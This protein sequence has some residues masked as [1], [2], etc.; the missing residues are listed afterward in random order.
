VATRFVAQPPLTRDDDDRAFAPPPA[1]DEESNYANAVDVM[2]LRPLSH[3]FLFE[4]HGEAANVNSLDEVPDSSWFENRAVR[5]EELARGPCSEEEPVLPLLIKKSKSGGTT[6]GFL[7]EDAL[8]R[9]YMVKLDSMPD[10][11][12]ELSTAADAIVSRLYWAVGF[13]APC[14]EVV[15]ARSEQ[16]RVDPRATETLATGDK[17]L[18]SAE[19]V[20]QLLSRATRRSD[21]AVRIG[22]S[23]FIAGEPI[24]TWRTEGTRTDD[25]NDVIPHE[26]RRELR[27]EYLLAAW[28]AHWDSRGPNSFDTFVRRPGAAAGHGVHYFLDFSE[29]L[30]GYGPALPGLQ[31]R[32]GY[33][34]VTDAP[35]IFTDFV[36]LGLTRKPWDDLAVDPRFPNLGYFDAEH[37][38]PARFAPQTPQVRWARAERADLAWMARRLARLDRAHLR[39]AM[40][41]GRFADPAEEE[42]LADLLLARRDKILRWSF[43]R[44]SP[45]AD[46][47]VEGGSLCANDVTIAAGL[48]PPSEVVY[49]PESSRRDGARVCV[50]LPG[51]SG[52]RTLDLVRIERG[53]RT[54]AR[55]HV[56]TAAGKTVLI[57]LERL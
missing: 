43:E 20:A 15:F 3:L 38:D 27:G 48:A 9:K 39:E 30:G 36:T 4:P 46:F 29:S 42:H 54:V 24:G 10:H 49:P 25:P 51:G 28:V 11:Q 1:M 44:V 33:E 35:Q 55:A 47:A 52:Y 5:P 40:R 7:V 56:H 14:N 53:R 31:A 57:G 37:F 8:R 16:L 12:P 50:P 45:L 19:R 2:L 34:T 17:R 23:R 21:G 18:L 26:D 6:P 32:I 41:A 22:A 13:N